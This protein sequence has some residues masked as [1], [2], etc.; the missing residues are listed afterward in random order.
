LIATTTDS[1]PFLATTTIADLKTSGNGGKVENANGYDMVWVDSD[2]ATALDFE[3]EKYDATTGEIVHWVEASAASSTNKT[4]YLYYGN[5]SISTDQSD[6]EGTW[7]SNFVMVQ[8]LNESDIDGGAGDIKDSTSNNNDGTTSGMDT[9]DDVAA[10]IGTGFDFDGSNDYVGL[11]T[12]SDLDLASTNFTIT[13]WIKRNTEE[14]AQE[15]IISKDVNGSRG[16]GFEVSSNKLCNERDGK[17]VIEDTDATVFL[18]ANTWYF[19]TLKFNESSNTYTTYVNGVQDG[20]KIRT[21]HLSTSAESRIGARA[22]PGYEGF[23]GGIIEELRISSSARDAGWIK[24]EYNNQ[25]DTTTFTTVGSEEVGTVPSTTFDISGTLYTDEGSTQ[26]TAGSVSIKLTIATS[27]P[28]VFATTTDSGSGAWSI[29]GLTQETDVWAGVPI[30]VW[31]DGDANNRAFTLTKASSTTNDISGVDLYQNRIIVRHEGTSATST[32]IT[33]LATYDADD[34]SD[35]QFTANGGALVSN[36]GQEL[37]IWT[38]DTFAPGGAMTFHGNASTSGIDGGL[39][40]DDNATLTSGGNITFAGNWTA[41][42]G[43]TFTAGSDTVTFNASTS[44]TITGNSQSFNNLIISGNATT[45]DSFTVDGV[46]TIDSGK[47]LEIASGDIVTSGSSAGSAGPASWYNT[48]FSYRR[49]FTFDGDL[50]ATTT[51]S[52][53]F[54]ATTTIADLK[55]TGNGGDVTNANGYDMVWVDSDDTTA[56][57]FEVE[58]YDA[59][60]GEIVHWVEASA[61][62]STNKTIYLYY[63]NSTIS[64]DQSDAAGTWDSNFVMVQHLNES[65]I[66]GGAGDIKDSTSNNNDG[67]TSGMDTNDDVAA[68]IGTGFDFD[69]TDDYIQTSINGTTMDSFTYSVW[70]NSDKLTADR[71][72][73]DSNST[74]RFIFYEYGA[75]PNKN[76]AIFEGSENRRF[77]AGAWDPSSWTYIS[78]TVDGSTGTLYVDGIQTGTTI[79]TTRLVGDTFD[80][81]LF[82][83]QSY[84]GARRYGGDFDEVRVSTS[85][86]DAGW[87]KTEYNN[88]VDTT[89]F[90][91]VG[92]EEEGPVDSVGINGTINGAGTLSIQNSNLGTGGT[93]SSRVRMDGTGATIN[94]PARTYGGVVEIYSSGSAGQV[95]LNSGTH[96]FSSALYG[97]ADGSGNITLDGATNNPTVSITGDLDFTGT[98]DGSEVM[99]SGTGAWTMSGNVLDFTGGTFTASSTNAFALDSTVSITSAGNSLASTT[100]SGTATLGDELNISGNALISGTIGAQDYAVRLTGSSKTLYGSTNA[101]GALRVDGSYTLADLDLTVG[102]TTIASGG[103][104]TVDSGRTLTSTSTLTLEGTLAGTGTTTLQ[105]SNLTSGGTLSNNIRFDATDGDLT[106]IARTY[107]GNVEYYN[108]SGSSAR[109]VTMGAGTFNFSSNLWGNVASTKNITLAGN[110]NNPTVNVTGNV[111]FFNP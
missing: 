35:I 14:A 89:T 48:D 107:G 94:I 92:S 37:H 73:F 109:T 45:T 9:N 105:H 52:F 74:Q 17:W 13:A 27:T 75:F 53:P 83:M 51:D 47:T 41:D 19:V 46:L 93:L 62:S 59:T 22:Y 96:T 63:G 102:T 101:L 26:N 12:N 67:T 10:Q 38:G 55:T 24:T 50:I 2:N 23:F 30:S 36:A 104:L 3:V 87:I 20:T 15:F 60:T 69:G 65:D 11:G 6:A 66:D 99:W 88:Q 32:T 39:H 91:T 1:F 98:G 103:T 58:K 111:D 29:Q 78:M 61:A 54:L 79:D 7:D 56:L 95:S 16:Y 110:T 71:A 4:I 86:R 72:F 68:Q 28:G 108:N 76:L 77:I 25:V 106:M 18:S 84:D 90:T 64:T 34:D 100:I 81:T 40:I 5:P 42:T 21:G 70:F 97:K 8:H 85:I 33:D 82:L 44:R 57:D 31:V 43:S 49:S 80:T